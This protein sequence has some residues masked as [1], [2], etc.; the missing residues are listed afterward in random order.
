VSAPG[1][2]ADSGAVWTGSEALVWGGEGAAGS[3]ASGGAYNPA[4]DAWRLLSN[5]GGPIARSGAGTVWSGS[6]LLV[7]GGRSNGS[8]VAA[9]Q[10]VNPQPTWYFYRKP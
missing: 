4:T 10:R 5:G 2:R 6:E 7:Y 9:L 1:G 8:P 3:L